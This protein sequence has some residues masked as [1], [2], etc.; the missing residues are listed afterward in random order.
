MPDSYQPA[1]D[2]YLETLPISMAGYERRLDLASGIASVRFNHG[3]VFVRECL[4]HQ[5]ED[6]LF[7]R[8]G[9]EDKRPFSG[10]IWLDRIF[11]PD[12]R[13][14]VRLEDDGFLRLYGRVAGGVGFS[15]EVRILDAGGGTLAVRNNKLEFSG[16]NSLFLAVDIAVAERGAIPGTGLR[17]RRFRSRQA[18]YAAHQTV[19]HRR[20]ADDFSLE[21]PTDPASAALPTD[22]RTKRVRAGK[23]D[24]G[25]PLLFFN[26]GRYLML[27][28][29][30][31]GR[32]PANLQG[33]W[34]EAIQPPWRSD[35]HMNINLQMNYWFADMCG[36]GDCDQAL[37]H[38]LLAFLPSG[39]RAA[40]KLWGCNGLWL[41]HCDDAWHGA[42]PEAYHWSVWVGATAWMGQHFWDHYE[43]T[44]DR[45]FLRSQAYPF[46]KATAEFFAD[47]LFERK[48]GYLHICPSQSPENRFIPGP[49]TICDS[50]SIDIQLA[51]A[52]LR[53]AAQAADIL[54]VD[55]DDAGRWRVMDGKLPPLRIGRDG[56]LLEWNMELTTEEDP[57]HRHLSPLFGVYPAG[58]YDL[59]DQPELWAAARKLMEH[60]L[61]HGGGHTGW[62][63]A[64]VAC[65]YAV[66]G[67]GEKFFEHLSRLI[68]MQSSDSLL[69][70][71]PPDI[72]QIDGN[73]GGA[74][75][76]LLAL[77][78]SNQGKIKLLPAL[79]EAW[80]YSRV[81]GLRARGGFVIDMEWE[82]CRLKTAT[83]RS[84]V[85]GS[86]TLRLKGSGYVLK[87]AN[88]QPWNHRRSQAD[89]L[90]TIAFETIP[91]GT[92]ILTRI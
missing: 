76:M 73:F 86:C 68:S 79:P 58:A 83:I 74:A 65:L 40:K 18:I 54:G 50:S 6:L 37:F 23:T 66:F 31:T 26:F 49:I 92:Y 48:D 80:P 45:D 19:F 69:D 35:Y 43:Y 75:A 84:T 41:A 44:R 1:G 81:T 20:S 32:L 27:S 70:L 36:L 25:L 85:G 34:N 17:T 12:C 21:L 38:Y 88:S 89:G 90:D 59:A 42:T 87:A 91:G 13:P 5:E 8:L 60:R 24:P 14:R 39:R 78:R 53:A 9:F 71:H 30:A 11:D 77:L 72:F 29:S 16:A 61:A 46:L 15:T 22:E 10:R 3:G 82:D 52:A 4:A 63:R 2:L 62:S 28:S 56:R 57:G 33:K 55:A 51:H 7:V 64:W 67:D 47:F